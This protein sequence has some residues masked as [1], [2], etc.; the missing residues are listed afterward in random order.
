MLQ[1]IRPNNNDVES[2][3]GDAVVTAKDNGFSV[4]GSIHQV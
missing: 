4:T 1:T 2:A 3:F